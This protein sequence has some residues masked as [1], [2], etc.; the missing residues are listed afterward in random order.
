MRG[1][2]VMLKIE[3]YLLVTLILLSGCATTKPAQ[4]HDYAVGGFSLSQTPEQFLTVLQEENIEL[5]RT[6]SNELDGRVTEDDGSFWYNSEHIRMHFNKD[7]T[8]YGIS[9][10]STKYSTNEGLKIGDTKSKMEEVYGEDYLLD[11]YGGW[12]SYQKESFYLTFLILDDKITVWC[13]M[14][15]TIVSDSD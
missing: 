15:G 10:L 13:I 4:N 8:A 9:I 6:Y 3:A 2:Q 7:G 14:S 12:H 1:E 5:D 11:I